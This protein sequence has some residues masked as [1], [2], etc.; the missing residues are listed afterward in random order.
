MSDLTPT[1]VV[2]ASNAIKLIFIGPYG[3]RAGWR[4]LLFLPVFIIS[5]LPLG[6]VMGAVAG[7][8]LSPATA[9][10]AEVPSFAIILLG[11]FI[12]A[13]FERRSL[14]DYGLPFRRFLGKQFWTGALWGFVMISFVIGLMAASH[15]YSPGGLALAPIEILKY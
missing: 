9:I 1:V 10:T 7:K 15:A 14:A 5:T 2:P 4:L 3:L 13:R 12:F 6:L 11:T 8:S